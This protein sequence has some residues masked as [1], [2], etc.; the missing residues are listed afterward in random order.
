MTAIKQTRQAVLE[1][2]SRS[3][4]VVKL[5]GPRPVSE[6]SSDAAQIKKKQKR[7][8]INKA[9]TKKTKKK[10]AP[11]DINGKETLTVLSQLSK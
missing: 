5:A 7:K 6:G 9:T 10:K 8:S 1:P 4:G 3:C 11:W 2:N